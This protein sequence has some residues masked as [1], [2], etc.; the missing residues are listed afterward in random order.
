MA[1]A[2]LYEL[3]MRV[4][5]CNK[6]VAGP[7][8]GTTPI[9]QA[10]WYLTENAAAKIDPKDLATRQGMSYVSFRHKFKQ[11]TGLGPHQY[12]LRMK[13][14]LAQNLLLT[15]P[16]SIK[17]ITDKIGLSD[18]YHFSRLFRQIVGQSPSA[19][20]REMAGMIAS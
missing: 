6:R 5:L 12:H 10:A 17:E 2:A 14:Q 15:T 7:S 16:H 13:V 20:R 4:I 8:P 18:P 19:F 1:S 11:Q 3:L 9:D